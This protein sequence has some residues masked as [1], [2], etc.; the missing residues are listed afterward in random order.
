MHGITK[1]LGS[2]LRGPLHLKPLRIEPLARRLHGRD[3]RCP[4]FLRGLIAALGSSFASRAF[5]S[6]AMACCRCPSSR[7]PAHSA[8]DKY[9]APAPARASPSSPL[10]RRLVTSR[11]SENLK[12]E[13]PLRLEPLAQ[14]L[15]VGR[16]RCCWPFPRG[17]ISALGSSFASRVS[18]SVWPSNVTGDCHWRRRT[19]IPRGLISEL[20]SSVTS[21][22]SP[23][24]VWRNHWRWCSP[25][26]H[27][28]CEQ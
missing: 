4:P 7:T 6:S 19:P 15:H 16:C 21:R 22:V 10:R 25:F 17:L 24:S 14:R 27:G 3:S 11:R 13:G 1:L 26:S 9:D 5:P 2:P 18:P 23:S 28:W 12:P 8:I 20:G